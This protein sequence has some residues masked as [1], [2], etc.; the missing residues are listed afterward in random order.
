MYISDP[1]LITIGTFVLHQLIFW[2]TNGI[3]LLLTYVLFPTRSMKYKIQKN[4]HVEAKLIKQCA[5]S[6]FINQLFLLFPFL[7]FI[8][9][10][11]MHLGLRWHLPFPPWHRIAFE[12]VSFI[13]VTEI[14]FF[15]SHRLLHVSFLYEYIHKQH[16]QFRAP[17]G[18]ACEYAHPI[19]FLVSNIGPVV[20]GPLIF[21]SHLLTTW[22]WLLFALLG[23]INHHS[24]YKLPG[25][26]G[27]GLAN[28]T[29]HDFHHAQF[30]NNFGL[31]GILDRLHGTDKAWRTKQLKEQQNDNGEENK[32]GRKKHA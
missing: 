23:T 4:I 15:Y 13:G 10:L 16:H 20:I 29:F 19:E 24:G 22:L 2:L 26:L 30:T 32:R 25:I 27:N 11:F 9:P 1:I 18:M 12:L 5:R 21:R 31:L 8:C 17:I 7:I 28:P 6:V 3:I 14:F